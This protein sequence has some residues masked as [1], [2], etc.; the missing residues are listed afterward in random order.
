MLLSCF[1]GIGTAALVLQLLCVPLI[2]YIAWEIDRECIQFTQNK[3]P[4]V[5]H[6]GDFIKDDI[7]DLMYELDQ[8]DPDHEAE[9]LFCAG[10]PCPDFSRIR[11][12][13][14][15][16]K[17]GPEGKKFTQFTEFHEQV[18]NRCN[19]QVRSVVENVVFQDPREADDFSKALQCTPVV[20]DAADFG[21]I[22]RPRL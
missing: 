7:D 22:R 5:R 21:I 9:I 3:F 17:A 8:I 10:P 18:R 16:G 2:A 11:G 19:R 15:P 14:A 6:R 13:K 12:S 1:D 20:C 4:K